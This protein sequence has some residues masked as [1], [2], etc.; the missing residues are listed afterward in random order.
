M[1]AGSAR[2]P[3]AIPAAARVSQAVVVCVGADPLREV[4][5]ITLFERL[6]RQL[7]ELN[8]IERIMVLTSQSMPAALA[9]N[10]IKKPVIYRNVSSNGFW[11]TLWEARAE[12]DQCF[13]A[14]TANF[15]VDQR[16][17]AWLASQPD[18]AMLVVREGDENG[19]AA[20][21]S[22]AALENPGPQA[23]TLRMVAV[24]SLPSYWEAMHGEIPLHLHRVANAADAEAGWRILLDHIQRRAQELP[25]RCFDPIFENLIVRRLAGTS[26]TA[27]QVT[28]FTTMLGFAV[29]ALFYTGWLRVGVMLGIVVEVLDGVDGK[30]ARITRT[31]S[32]AGEYEHILDF[33][34]EN[35][36]YLALGLYFSR[37]G[38]PHAMTAALLMVVFD[39][40]DTLVYAAVDVRWG[41]SLD[42]LSPFLTRFRLIGGRRNIYGWMFLIGFFVGFPGYTFYAATLWAGITAA[43]HTASMIKMASRRL[44][45][46]QLTAD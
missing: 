4:G 42:N 20:R 27:N 38:F 24:T 22:K 16:L 41:R 6:M 46:D 35:S 25:S 36:W 26:I 3:D 45:V 31:T 13:I 11:D 9:S 17:L 23:T 29:A 18:D 39:L 12:L 40:I 30:L 32:R 14:V 10:R 21:L 19:P 43:I 5:G 34:Y 44:S 15:L 1:A 8:G 37:A 28:M 2:T 7:N 33:F